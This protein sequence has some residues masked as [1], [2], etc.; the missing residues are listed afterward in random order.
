[1]NRAGKIRAMFKK[2]SPEAFDEART[3]SLSSIARGR[4]SE[5]IVG[6]TA[7]RLL[8]HGIGDVLVVTPQWH[9]P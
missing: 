9:K 1:L 3:P 4:F 8:H 5:F 7:E 2:V 6:N